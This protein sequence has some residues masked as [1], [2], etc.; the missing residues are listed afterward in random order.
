MEAQNK[1]TVHHVGAW[2]RAKLNKNSL[3]KNTSKQIVACFFGNTG[4]VATVPLEHRRTICLPKLFRLIKKTNMRRRII[5]HH[6]NASS[7]TSAQTTSFWTGPNVE[8]MGHPLYSP[9]LSPNDLF[10]FQYIEN[11]IRSRRFSSP[12]DAVVALK[13]HVL[14]WFDKL[15]EGMHALKSNKNIF[16]D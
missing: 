2:T 4:D 11:K 7:H 8:L 5:V 13:N 15:F 10:L 14:E 3:W 6:D 1:A 12:E 16:D 9:D